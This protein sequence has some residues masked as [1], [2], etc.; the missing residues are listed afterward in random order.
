[1]PSNAIL[2]QES[3]GLSEERPPQAAYHARPA[4]AGN[5]IERLSGSLCPMDC[6]EIM[7]AYSSAHSLSSM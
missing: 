5:H 3:E 2:A 1:M 4:D 6:M 7:D